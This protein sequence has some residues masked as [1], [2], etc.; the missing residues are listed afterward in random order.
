MEGFPIRRLGLILPEWRWLYEAQV[1]FFTPWGAV[2]TRGNTGWCVARSSWSWGFNTVLGGIDPGDH[3][4]RPRLT[5]V[6]DVW[7]DF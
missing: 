2:S 6:V 7:R 5:R 1:R 3:R 4:F